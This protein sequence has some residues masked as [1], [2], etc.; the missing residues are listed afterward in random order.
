MKCNK[1]IKGVIMKQVA[2][3]EYIPEPCTCMVEKWF[4]GL[5]KRS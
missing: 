1:C 4:K 3:A 5:T 2:L